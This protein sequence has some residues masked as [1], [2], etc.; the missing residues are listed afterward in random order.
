LLIVGR[1]IGTALAGLLQ[2]RV[3]ALWRAAPEYG[4]VGYII[5]LWP[6]GSR[7]I[8]GSVFTGLLDTGL[9]FSTYNVWNEKGEMLRSIP[10][11]P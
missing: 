2:Q 10:S 7:M 8:K 1:Y 9:P 11:S 6:S 3:P 4:S 5:V